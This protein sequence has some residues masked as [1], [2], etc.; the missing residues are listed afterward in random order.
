MKAIFADEIKPQDV[1]CAERDAEILVTSVETDKQGYIQVMG[2]YL[3]MATYRTYA[4]NHVVG[5]VHRS[6]GEEEREEALAKAT[7]LLGQAKRDV[8]S[9]VPCSVDTT[10]FAALIDTLLDYE[11]SRDPSQ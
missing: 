4:P 10:K 3:G 11:L 2:K 7:Q 6:L 9:Y 1:I 5:I 8:G